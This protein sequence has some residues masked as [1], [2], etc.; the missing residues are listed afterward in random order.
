MK[1]LVIGGL[2]SIGTA[3]V[4]HLLADNYEVIVH[5]HRS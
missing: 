2:G 4:E 5:Y 1:A 3:I